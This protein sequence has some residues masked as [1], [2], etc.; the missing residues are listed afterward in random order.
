ITTATEASI[1]R[2]EKNEIVKYRNGVLPLVRLASIFGL[3]AEPRKEFPVLV[4]GTGL[5]AVGILADRVL[6]Q[7]EIVVRPVNDPL[8]KVPGISGATELGDGRAVLI[9]DSA[10]LAQGARARQRQATPRRL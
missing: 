9:L 4:I 10:A 1:N 5:N 8:L 3:G 2:F 6:G 7:R